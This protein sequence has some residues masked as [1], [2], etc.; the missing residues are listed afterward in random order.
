M[1]TGAVA[2]AKKKKSESRRFNTLVRMDDEMCRKAKKLAALRETSMAELFASILGPWVD[3][4][5]AKEV[6]KETKKLKGESEA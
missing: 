4:E 5:F 2:V 3:R 6:S 1:P